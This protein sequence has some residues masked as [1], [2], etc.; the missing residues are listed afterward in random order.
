MISLEIRIN[1]LMANTLVL[2]SSIQPCYEIGRDI[3]AT[4]NCRSSVFRRFMDRFGF[5]DYFLDPKKTRI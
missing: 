5:T 4:L 3:H 1:P 2:C